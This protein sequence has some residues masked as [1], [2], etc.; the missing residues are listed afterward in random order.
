MAGVPTNESKHR[1]KKKRWLIVG[2]GRETEYNYFEAMRHDADVGE[3]FVLVVKKGPGRDQ[4]TIVRKAVKFKDAAM[5]SKEHYDEYWCVLDVEE[6]AKSVSLRKAVVLAQANDLSLCLSNPAFEI[7]FLLHFERKAPH[8]QDCA[9]VVAELDKQWPAVFKNRY[10]KSERRIF[11]RLRT[12]LPEAIKNAEWL[13]ETQ[14]QQA[15]IPDCNPSTD[16]HRLVKRLLP[17]L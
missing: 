17:D 2:E 4:E 1:I 5:K 14:R 10:D 6:S 7:W 11:E 8:Y 13:L 16:V 15:S 3:R 12:R 9:A